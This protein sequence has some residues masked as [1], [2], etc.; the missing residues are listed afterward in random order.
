M[1]S[2]SAEDMSEESDIGFPA[3]SDIV[4]AVRSGDPLRLNV[5][6]LSARSIIALDHSSTIVVD[7]AKELGSADDAMRWYEA[8]I[9]SL[10][11]TA[12]EREGKR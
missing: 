1:K 12:S 7:V 8:L 5:A 11:E 3:V 9:R 4:E 10:D 2:Y 6:A